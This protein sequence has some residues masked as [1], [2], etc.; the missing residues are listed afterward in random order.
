VQIRIFD[1]ING[2]MAKARPERALAAFTHWGNPNFG[3]TARKNGDRWVMYDLMFGG[4]GGRQGADGAEAM[5]PVMNCAN[6]PVEVHESNNP[7]LIHRLELIPD[8]GGPGE[9][10]GGCALRKD[11]ELLDDAVV[12]LLGDRHIYPPY[13][14]LGG[15]AGQP[16]RTI[17]VREGAEQPLGSKEVKQ[18]K[19][20]DVL[21]FRLAGAGGYGDPAKRAR[22][23]IAHDLHHGFVTPEGARRDYGFDAEALQRATEAETA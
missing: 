21:S 8:S 12:T 15:K 5:C 9:F 6:I 18:L 19:R 3:G 17:L 16:A 1:A 7:V 2:A 22:E 14:L 10:R 20:G 4:Y 13:G 11:V 23:R